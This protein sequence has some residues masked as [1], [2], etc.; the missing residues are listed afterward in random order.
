MSQVQRRMLLIAIGLTL[1]SPIAAIA[2]PRLPTV[3]L[4]WNDTVKPSPYQTTFL[5]AMREKGHVAGRSIQIDDGIS[6]Q[7]YG[8]MSEGAAQLVRNKVDVI[9]TFGATATFAA[10]KATKDIPIVMVIGSDPVATGVVKSL[11]HP[12][13][14][15]TGVTLVNGE[16]IAKRMQLL[17]ELIPGM[18]RVGI[19]FAPASGAAENS[20]REIT[21]AI[22]KLKLDPSFAG[23]R[24]PE[25]I[26]SAFASLARSRVDAVFVHGS[27]MLAANSG[28]VIALADRFRMPAM[29]AVLKYVDAGGLIAYATD[30]HAAVAEAAGYVDKILKG[31]K[32]RD[33]PIEQVRRFELVVNLKTAKAMGIK[34]PQTI[35]QRVDR[36]IE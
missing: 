13:S 28:R 15:I 27:S 21:E 16:L 18:S 9:V 32:P 20:M 14:N 36:V 8:G 25:E 2:Q 22:R 23:V 24:K 34:V 12:E 30:S 1:A 5:R 29:Y 26:E 4:L 3:G 17:T 33:L 11:S 19:L 7:G 31:A 35:L 6:L 10:A